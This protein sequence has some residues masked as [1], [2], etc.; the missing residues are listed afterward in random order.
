MALDYDEARRQA[1][2][3]IDAFNRHDLDAYEAEFHEQITHQSLLADRRL[4]QENSRVDGKQAH[5][6]HALGVGRESG[7]APRARGSLHRAAWICL[8]DSPGA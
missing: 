7:V 1:T 3:W 5:R 6:E 4:G 2:A 8:P